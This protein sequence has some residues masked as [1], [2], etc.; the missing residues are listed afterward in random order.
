MF[1]A[2]ELLPGLPDD[3]EALVVE[4]RPR[5][6]T[7]NG[8][9]LEIHD[10]TLFAHRQTWTPSLCGHLGPNAVDLE[11]QGL[12]SGCA[13]GLRQARALLAIPACNKLVVSVRRQCVV[14][15]FRLFASGSEE[16]VG[17]E[18][19]I[20]QIL[21][22]GPCYTLMETG[23]PQDRRLLSATNNVVATLTWNS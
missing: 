14:N 23:V 20:L 18:N 21:G 12:R 5:T 17:A 19:G 8:T 16:L 10:S 3:F 9:T 11:V 2:D 6:V 13:G 1:L 4:Q 15:G 22:K 7:R